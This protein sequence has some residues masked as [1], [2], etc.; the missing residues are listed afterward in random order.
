MQL[1]K[2][3]GRRAGHWIGEAQPS[4]KNV[5]YLWEAIEGN[6]GIGKSQKWITSFRS[7]KQR[8]KKKASNENSSMV[9][10]ARVNRDWN[11]RRG[12]GPLPTVVG[13]RF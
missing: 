11:R 4:R 6:W 3:G 10:G 12:G 8:G 1:S 2:K 9:L 5:E 13:G 7:E